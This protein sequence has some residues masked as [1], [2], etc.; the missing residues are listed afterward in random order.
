MKITSQDIIDKEFRVKFRGF[1]MA[2]VDTF[3]EE[4]AEV[5]FK[6]NEE[7]TQLNEKILALQKKI[8]FMAKTPPQAQME[9]PSELGNSLDEL[10]QDTAAISAELVVLKQ[11]RSTFASLEKSIKEAVIS[12]QQASTI[13]PP[14][15]QVELPAELGNSLDELKQDIAAI[16]AELATLKEDRQAC[17]I[18]ASISRPIFSKLRR[19]WQRGKPITLAK[20][21]SN[22]STG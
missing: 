7:N 20:Q 21:P 22:F 1:D 15:G 2:E 8:K 18:S 3:L 12:L 11:D 17:G 6:L 13:A 10:K 4:V 16:N 19:K 9:L 5:F 14:P